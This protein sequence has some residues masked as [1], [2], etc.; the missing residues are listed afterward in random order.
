MESVGARIAE[1][2][3]GMVDTDNSMLLRL[4]ANRKFV[5]RLDI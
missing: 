2:V 4:T 3:F 5:P 1:G